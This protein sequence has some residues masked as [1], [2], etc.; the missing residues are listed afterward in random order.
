METH[1][2]RARELAQQE[3]RERKRAKKEEAAAQRAG[4]A[5][6][7]DGSLAAETEGQAQTAAPERIR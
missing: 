1:G 4:K 2:K 5:A 6:A 7:A 3:R